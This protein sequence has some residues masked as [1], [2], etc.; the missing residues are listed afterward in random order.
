MTLH[1]DAIVQLRHDIQPKRGVW[2]KKGTAGRVSSRFLL[3]RACM[4]EFTMSNDETVVVR[5]DDDDLALVMTN[6]RV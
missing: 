3:H 1:K 5:V 4:V 6:A 2:I